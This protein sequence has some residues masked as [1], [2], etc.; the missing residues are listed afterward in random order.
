[1]KRCLPLVALLACGDDP[2][3]PVACADLSQ[4]SVFVGGTETVALCFE[5]PEGQAL[6]LSASSLDSS[7][8]AAALVGDNVQIEGRSPGATTVRITATDPDSLKV[9]QDLPVLVPNRPPTGALDDARLARG[10]E[11][12]INLADHFSDED[13][14]ALTYTASSSAPSIASATVS[15]MVLLLIS[16]LDEGTATISVTA[17]DGDESVTARF[18]VTVLPTLLSDNFNSAGTLDDWEL[19]DRTSA[20]IRDGYFVL[21]GE[22]SS[23]GLATQEFGGV[24]KDWTVDVALRT[25]DE[26]ARAGILVWTGHDRFVWYTF[27]VGEADYGEHGTG[28][29]VFLWYDAADST[30]YWNPSWSMGTSDAINDSTDVHVSFSITREDKLHIRVNGTLLIRRLEDNAY[31]QLAGPSLVRR[32]VGISLVTWPETSAGGTSS[33]NWIAFAAGEF[34]ERD[35]QA[36]VRPDA[37]VGRLKPVRIRKR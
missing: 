26:D 37:V 35:Q 30:V 11:M 7:I 8:A 2:K 23:R 12:T 18:E 17:S 28:N 34:L 20:Q 29:W 5:D 36:Y 3:P 1:M 31:N 21:T 33:M 4:V 16:A 32:A 15:D 10:I 27:L 19:G 13:G 9:D 25:T 24:A 22:T 14:Q 6:A